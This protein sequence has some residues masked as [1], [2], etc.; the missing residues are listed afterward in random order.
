MK[1]STAIHDYLLSQRDEGN[2]D[3]IDRILKHGTNLELQIN[4]SP[5]GGEPIHGR[6]NA[7]T[8]GIDKWFSFRIPKGAFTDDANWSDMPMTYDLPKHVDSIGSTGWL[9][10]ERKS[11]WAGYDFD[12]IVGHADGVG[13]AD[14][15]LE[16]VRE[17]A[18]KL[19]YV[20]VRKST[21]GGGLHL[22]VHFDGVETQNHTEHAALARVVLQQMSKDVGF[23]LAT[24]VDVCG[25]NMWIAAKRASFEKGSFAL[26]KPAT[27]PFTQIP[28]HWKENV[29]VLKNRKGRV[30]IPGVDDTK[31]NM[32]DEL[33]SA[34]RKVELDDEHNALIEELAA[35]G[36]CVWVPD[37]H[38]LQTHTTLLKE[39]MEHSDL[40]IAGVFMTNSPGTNTSE[41][42]VF[43]H[44]LDY[45]AWK[46][47]RFGPGTA[48]HP[49]WDQDGRG[50]TSTFY[51]VKPT[52]DTAAHV[53]GGT[54]TTRGNFDFKKASDAVK[55][56]KKLTND[57]NFDIEMSPAME[58]RAATVGRTKEGEIY[59]QIK[60]MEGDEAT[61]NWNSS[62]KKGY[63]TCLVGVHAAPETLNA[64]DYDNKV[65]CLAT[66][67]NKTAG[68]ATITN[69]SVWQRRPRQE[70][71]IVLQSLGLAP[72]E[73]DCVMGL[74]VTQA[75]TLVNIPFEE[76][77]PGDR[78]WNADA[79]Q[80]R[81]Q[82]EPYDTDGG[83]S[84]HPYWDMILNHIGQS[85]DEPLKEH[86]W[87]KT[88]GIA[89]GRQYL[90]MWIGSMLQDP[91]APLPYLFMFG[92]EN[93]GKSIFHEAISL[94]VT[95]G[96]V[97]A[98]RA[99]TS[100]NDF[101]G[102]LEGC[103]LAVVEEKNIAE[104]PGAHNKIKQAVTAE[105][106][107]IRRMRTDSYMVQNT[108]HWVQMS[109]EPDA[110]PVFAGDTRIVA[111]LV[112]EIESEVPKPML[113]KGLTAEAPKFL[114]SIL[115]NK[116]PPADG[117]LRLPVIETDFKQEASEMNR[118]LLDLFLDQACEYLEG[119]KLPFENFLSSFNETLPK[120]ETKWSSR[121]LLRELNKIHSI[122]VTRGT[123]EQTAVHGIQWK[124]NSSFAFEDANQNVSS[125]TQGGTK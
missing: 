45:G 117:R 51:N 111:M 103:V 18:C 65:R 48:E 21:G 101:N 4:A 20:E 74:A 90:E 62:D 15:E 13:I 39:V 3:L 60:A 49:S 43:M 125:L 41:P 114:H 116:I 106:I 77:Y 1:T 56:V 78:R 35:K 97:F 102:E 84:P 47:Y 17:A 24:K 52:L 16:R 63:H 30:R 10:S 33:T 42:N 87:A 29:P 85:L 71:K 70:V 26:I 61:G 88:Y 120:G 23:D 19:D 80:L 27:V 73:A 91:Y 67:D 108:T 89:T 109:N 2:K 95:K 115:T 124:P 25:S 50:W 105:S 83:E 66:P 8:D 112:P 7:Y 68:W 104:T 46:L 69:N 36:C 94:L 81:Y 93:S 54:K 6:R 58:G 107:S 98:D 5:D 79:P 53:D 119:A 64:M 40:E 31:Q 12:T 55:M 75:W 76:E 121:K 86:E 32:F 34:H 123:G 38:L 110:C 99:L 44:P 82:P 118:G 14:T 122:V 96:V 59:L 113:L 92:P 72:S 57:P 9:W 100:Q 11:L 28:E 22:Y 37:H